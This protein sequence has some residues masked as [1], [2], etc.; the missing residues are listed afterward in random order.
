MNMKRSS[1]LTLALALALAQFASICSLLANAEAVPAPAAGT[2]SQSHEQSG[3]WDQ[4]ALHGQM[5]K[6]H[7]SAVTQLAESAPGPNTAVIKPAVT[8]ARVRKDWRIAYR[9]ASDPWLYK[10]AAS[11]PAIIAAICE[12]PGAAKRLAKNRHIGELA[13]CDHYLCRRLTRWS[14]STWALVRNP[15]ADK[16]I[17]LDP[18][19]IYRAID[20]NPSVAHA[21]SKNIMFNQMISENPDL[22]KVIAIHM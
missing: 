5:D 6:A 22:G 14:G 3:S 21:L 15:Q 1:L 13:E 18:E 2:Q 4:P 17:A 9:L 16:V 20:K 8:S 12:H 7:D 10:A 11:D 19:G